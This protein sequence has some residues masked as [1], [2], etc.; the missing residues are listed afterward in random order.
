MQKRACL[1]ETVAKTYHVFPADKGK[2][3]IRMKYEYRKTFDISYSRCGRNMR[4]SPENAFSM[5]QDMNT[6]YFE[7][8]GSDNVSIKGKNN[9]LWVITKT[10]LH[11]IDIPKWGEKIEA[12]SATVSSRGFRTEIGTL[13]CRDGEP[14]LVAK[15]ELFIIDAS[16]REPR[17]IESI[18]YPK[19]METEPETLALSFFRLKEDFSA[20]EPVHRGVFGYSDIDYSRHVNNVMYARHLTDALAPYLADDRTIRDFE[21]QYRHECLE[22]AAFEVFCRQSAPDAVDLQLRSGGFEAVDARI[23]FDVLLKNS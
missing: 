20:E 23:V 14:V 4:L 22:N 15:Q 21:I 17:R 12:R 2:R 5:V 1:A 8:F 3:L 19:D 13:F 16:S 6:E 7:S 11:F 10:R 18:S 9:A